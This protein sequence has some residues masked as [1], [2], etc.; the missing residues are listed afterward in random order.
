MELMRL[1]S[2]QDVLQEIAEKANYDTLT[3]AGSRSSGE[4]SLELAFQRFKS[5]LVSPA[6]MMMDVDTLKNIND[7]Y[8]MPPVTLCCAV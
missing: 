2:R 7:S 5:E 8:G 1:E 3:S 6:V 4:R